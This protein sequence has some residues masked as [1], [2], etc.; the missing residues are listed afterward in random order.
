MWDTWALGTSLYMPVSLRFRMKSE[1]WKLLE[2][3][4]EVLGFLQ[5]L[6][7]HIAFS[8]T[9]PTTPMTF[10]SS[11]PQA[12]LK[13]CL[14][15]SPPG[16]LAW[17][18]LLTACQPGG[19]RHSEWDFETTVSGDHF[20]SLYSSWQVR[21]HLFLWES[22]KQLYNRY[23]LNPPL[24]KAGYPTPWTFSR[25]KNSGYKC[26]GPVMPKPCVQGRER[27]AEHGQ[28]WGQIRWDPIGQR[29]E[30]WSYLSIVGTS[31][32]VLSDDCPNLTSFRRISG[33][34]MGVSCG[35]KELGLWRQADLCSD[36]KS[37]SF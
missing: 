31:E 6:I 20:L 24:W 4:D 1:L 36:P 9:L 33:W 27:Q 37:T 2:P 23:F 21:M 32:K 14:I 5:V 26:P 8:P 25:L 22:S 13:G 35:G 15:R 11:K 3:W 18:L 17:F 28:V 10:C 19:W 16:L 7:G 34:Q 29:E 12:C 30:L